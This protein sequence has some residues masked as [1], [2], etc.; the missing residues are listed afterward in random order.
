MGQR[1][2]APVPAGR[3][4]H[5]LHSRMWEN[6]LGASATLWPPQIVYIMRR[7]TSYIVASIVVILLMSAIGRYDARFTWAR[8]VQTV[9]ASVVTIGLSLSHPLAF[10]VTRWR[11]PLFF[12]VVLAWSIGLLCPP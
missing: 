1:V 3:H 10:A 9:I 2:R 11:R 6:A 12:D 8:S 7:Q 5:I 4:R